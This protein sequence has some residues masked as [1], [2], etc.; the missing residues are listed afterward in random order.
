MVI[1]RY[2]V[3]KK[4]TGEVTI[5]GRIF[6]YVA[7]LNE[8][9]KA[10]DIGKAIGLSW[11]PSGQYMEQGGYIGLHAALIKLV[12][13]GVLNRDVDARYSVAQ[14]FS[15]E[16]VAALVQ[17]RKIELDLGKSDSELSALLHWMKEL[18]VE[19]RKTQRL[20]TDRLKKLTHARVP[21]DEIAAF[22]YKDSSADE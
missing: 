11:E 6:G 20:I 4:R 21:D 10:N 5:A 12:Q 3:L 1:G 22:L 17:L 19:Q 14:H 18:Q 8:P 16:E 9:V 15:P 13:A 7:T 2:V